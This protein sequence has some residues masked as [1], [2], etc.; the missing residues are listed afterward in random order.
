M[1]DGGR[2][3]YSSQKLGKHNFDDD[4]QD[5][6][7]DLVPDMRQKQNNTMIG[8]PSSK[9]NRSTASS[10]GG[11]ELPKGKGRHSSLANSVGL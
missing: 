8:K 4:D 5:E 3:L 7:K 1:S 10:G 6:E 11:L 2:D 9:L